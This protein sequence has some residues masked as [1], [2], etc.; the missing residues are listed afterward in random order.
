MIRPSPD[1]LDSPGILR[2]GANPVA[3]CIWVFL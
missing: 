1:F 3:L 2:I